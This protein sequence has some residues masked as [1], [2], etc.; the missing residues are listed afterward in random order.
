MTNHK[1]RIEH[2]EK[3][4]SYVFFVLFVVDKIPAY[5]PSTSFSQI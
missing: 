1:E 5:P 2:K 3:Y 4:F